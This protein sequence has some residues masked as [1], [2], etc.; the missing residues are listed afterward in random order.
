MPYQTDRQ[1]AFDALHQAFL[2]NLMAEAEV[3]VNQ[4]G[5]ESD[6]PSSFSE[7]NSSDTDTSCSSD[8][9]EPPTSS[10][11]LLHVMAQLYSTHYYNTCE[12]ISKDS[13][14]LHLLL[15]NYKI[16]CP[17][18]FRSY[19]RVSPGCFDDLAEAIKDDEIFHNNS[20]N[21]QMPVEQQLAI[22][23]YRF[24]HYGNAASTM[25]VALWA[26]V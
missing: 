21:A 22:A 26:G 7:S 13:N 4:P 24:G 18:I 8:N 11:V 1:V 16:N 17:E 20:N 12:P 15:Y 9:E 23:L 2:V 25:K 3:E 19:L 5:E 6:Y 14:Q 10:D